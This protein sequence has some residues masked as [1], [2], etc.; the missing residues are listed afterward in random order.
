MAGFQQNIFGKRKD[1]RKPVH[2]QVKPGEG[3][4]RQDTDV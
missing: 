2:W 3:Q 4:D 1:E